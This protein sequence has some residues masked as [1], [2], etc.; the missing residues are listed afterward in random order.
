MEEISE[1][2][3]SE[4]KIRLWYLYNMGVV[5]KS[6]NT[7]V[8]FDLPNTNIYN[9]S[10]DF[11]KY[12]D[13]LVI[14]HLHADHFDPSVVKEALK[15]G[16]FVVA[17]ND[18][19]ITKYSF[20]SDK[21]IIAKPSEKITLKGVEI[22]DYPAT[23]SSGYEIPVDWFLVTINEKNFLDTGD[24]SSFTY[25]PDFMDKQI[26]VFL[27]HFND[28]RD[29]ESMA[30]YVPNVKLVL[31]LH[32]LEL[33]HGSEIVDYM[34]YK[35]ALDGYVNGFWKHNLKARYVPLIWSESIAIN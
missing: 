10:A 30:K 33:G 2:Q 19:T 24:G 25:Q 15:R 31:P 22:T 3:V 32:T 8:A 35:N 1:T 9:D 17:P 11:T 28:E 6:S 5:V 7:T 27:A 16:V 21:L 20:N 23:H 4:G 26:D 29:A 14:T 18:T 12:I 13:I 34:M